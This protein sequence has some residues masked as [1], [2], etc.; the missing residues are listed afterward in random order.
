MMYTR[1]FTSMALVTIDT[2]IDRNSLAG[3][4][5]CFLG[6][7]IGYQMGNVLG[8]A[9]TFYRRL[10]EEPFVSDTG[11][12]ADGVTVRVDSAPISRSRDLCI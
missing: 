7:Q 3:D 5:A 8:F 9:H 2:S 11:T 10:I 4:E 12:W 1:P 6:D